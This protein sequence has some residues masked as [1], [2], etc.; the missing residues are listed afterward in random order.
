MH[1]WTTVAQLLVAA[2]LLLGAV[3]GVGLLIV[4]VGT[5]TAFER[6]DV[7]VVQWLADHRV[8]WLDTVSAPLAEMGNTEGDRRSA[9]S[10]RRCSRSSSP[11]GGGPRS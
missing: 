7:G 4:H 2:V 8:P 9:A 5:G 6:A 11:V 1:P 10:S 3:V